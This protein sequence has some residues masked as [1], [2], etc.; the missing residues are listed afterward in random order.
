MK[1]SN[2]WGVANQFLI[3]EEGRGALGNFLTKETF[4]SYDSTIAVKTYWETETET[5]LDR[6]N[7]DYSTTT[8]KY[9]N[10]FLGE[11]KTET[12]KKIKSGE[13]KLDNLN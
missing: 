9:R 4:K 6:D 2:E 3:V 7:W 1:V 5:K 8:G 11:N 12:E 13:Y 10:K